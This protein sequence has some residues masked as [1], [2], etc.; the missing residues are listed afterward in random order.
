MKLP[1][2]IFSVALPLLVIV[3][4]QGLD[5]AKIDE[6]MGRFGQKTGD[7]YRLCF[8]RTDLHVWVGGVE[9]NPGLALGSWAAFTVSDNAAMVMGEP[10][11]VDK[12]LTARLGRVI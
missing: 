9:I 6:A 5:T 8:P 3:A 2:L 7:V 1:L 10:V 4:V 11:L 12:R